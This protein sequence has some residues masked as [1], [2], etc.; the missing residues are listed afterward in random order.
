[1]KRI[2]HGERADCYFLGHDTPTIELKKLW[3]VTLDRQKT[4]TP[5]FL[6]DTY[7]YI[8][9]WKDLAYYAGVPSNINLT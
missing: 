4:S 5:I 2:T 8:D 7:A 6:N 9:G 3:A 1:M